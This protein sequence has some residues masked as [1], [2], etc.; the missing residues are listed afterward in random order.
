M[1]KWLEPLLKNGIEPFFNRLFLHSLERQYEATYSLHVKFLSLVFSCL[2]VFIVTYVL[3]VQW[4]FPQYVF[5]SIQSLWMDGFHSIGLDVFILLLSLWIYFITILF[6]TNGI[7]YLVRIGSGITVHMYYSYT[8]DHKKK[9]IERHNVSGYFG[10]KKRLFAHEGYVAWLDFIEF[11]EKHPELQHYRIYAHSIFYRYT[12]DF[13]DVETKPV[14]W[15][16]I[17]TCIHLI[18]NFQFQKAWSLLLQKKVTE[19]VLYTSYQELQELKP[20]FLQKIALYNQSHT[21][22]I[23]EPVTI[24]Q[25]VIHQVEEQLTIPTSSAAPVLAD[26][27]GGVL[28]DPQ[29]NH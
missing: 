29:S 12:R 22:P 4:F 8:I 3:P 27:N 10:D 21:D 26:G 1:R 14:G 20:Y 15:T 17:F 25:E 24:I 19:Q 7:F 6:L 18:R 11:L 23:L 13:K 16:R 28:N 9:E 5:P 2:Y